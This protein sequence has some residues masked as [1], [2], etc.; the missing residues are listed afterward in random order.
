[1]QHNREKA[2]FSKLYKTNQ[3][4]EGKSCDKKLLH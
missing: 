2:K 3:F 4:T 1:M